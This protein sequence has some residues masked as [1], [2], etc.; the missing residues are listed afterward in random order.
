[1]KKPIEY[2]IVLRKYEI[3]IASA[4]VLV[5]IIVL[6]GIYLK[7]NLSKA[8]QIF[9][10]QNELNTRLSNLKKKASSLSTLDQQYYKENLPK[11]NRVL[12]FDKDFVSLFST[13]DKL[14]EKTG[15]FIIRTDF[16]LDKTSN[17]P[18]ANLSNIEKSG[19]RTLTMTLEI[20]G[21][22][23]AVVQFLDSID[24]LSGRVI[25]IENAAINL[26]ENDNVAVTLKSQA[27]YYSGAKKAS[28]EIPLPQLNET[29][30]KILESIASNV[31]IIPSDEQEEFIVGKED[32]FN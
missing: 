24:D 14:Q 9:L 10:K 6:V 4:I 25:T 1:M 15:I 19:V 21:N 28:I 27:Y 29:E 5:V 26:K 22:K 30:L 23:S 16:K 12:P 32:L 11:L 18:S 7:P 13:F 17:N 31:E 8:Q 3:V 20:L 2:L